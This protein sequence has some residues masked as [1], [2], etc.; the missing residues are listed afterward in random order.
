MRIAIASDHAGF[1]QKDPLAEYLRA[2]GHEVVD[3]GPDSDERCDYPDYAD[4]V[5]RR[6]ARGEVDRG[7]LICGTGLGIAMTAD[8]VAGVRATPIQTVEFARLAREHND[9]N[10]IG[11]SGRFV[12]LEDNEK[13]LDAFLTTEF[14]GG[15][16]TARVEKMMRE[17][18]PAF[19]GVEA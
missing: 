18:D 7:V 11:L 2:Q 10:I 12:S 6:V 19:P 9:A 4:K 5:A 16:H 8:K 3:C 13:I 15:R 14:G 17:D 1:V